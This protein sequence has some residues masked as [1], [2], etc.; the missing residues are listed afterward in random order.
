MKTKE[1]LDILKEE[2]NS[3]NSK[4]AELSENELK[5]VT[6]GADTSGSG[7]GYKYCFMKYDRV[8]KDKERHQYE[9]IIE[10]VMTNDPNR[11]VMSELKD[12]RETGLT[13][14]S[15]PHYYPQTVSQLIS[16]Y[17]NYGGRLKGMTL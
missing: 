17:K 11:V 10:D 7:T 3:L 14:T 6:G 13:S 4:L 12:S 15:E 2:V 1:E 8:Y 9:L 5:E 16:D